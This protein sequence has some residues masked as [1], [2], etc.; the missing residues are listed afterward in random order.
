M[1]HFRRAKK[2]GCGG[3]RFYMNQCEGKCIAMVLAN[4]GRIENAS[5]IGRDP[6]CFMPLMPKDK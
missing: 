4:K 1:E 2:V 3:C 6:Y 5:L